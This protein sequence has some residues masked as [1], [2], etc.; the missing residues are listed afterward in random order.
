[1]KI[2]K[3]Y[4]KQELQDLVKKHNSLVEPEFYANIE[5]FESLITSYEFDTTEDYPTIVIPS[6]ETL[7]G[8]TERMILEWLPDAY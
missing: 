5:G 7:S 4:N 3:G 1:M 6:Y 8:H 2:I